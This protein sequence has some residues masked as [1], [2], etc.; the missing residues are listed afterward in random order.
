MKVVA[1]VRGKRREEQ[2]VSCDV[3]RIKARGLTQEHGV[4]F[5]ASSE[6]CTR[7]IRRNG[8][9]LRRRTSLAKRLLAS[10]EVV[11]YHR[12]III[13]RK[14]RLRANRNY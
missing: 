7:M 9:V 12:H 1:F 8:L 6:W 5:K 10:Y 2:A 14:E 3:I 4:Q 13:V 11:K